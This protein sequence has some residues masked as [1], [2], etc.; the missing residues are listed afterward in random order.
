[1]KIKFTILFSSLFF[2]LNA[3]NI[4]DSKVSFQYIQLPKIKI[5]EAI[6]TYFIS[7]KNSFAS[8]NERQNVLHQLRVD[9]ADKALELQ[10]QNWEIEFNKA[11]KQYL[12][13]LSVWKENENRGVISPKPQEP[14]WPVYPEPYELFPPVLTKPF[15]ELNIQNNFQL[16][17][18]DEGNSGVEISIDNL[19][20]EITSTK[21]SYVQN[22]QTP[23][24]TYKVISKYRMPLHVVVNFNGNK[25]YEKTF[26][27][28]INNFQLF[29]GKTEYDYQLWK[30]KNK[31]DNKDIWEETQS[32][33]WKQALKSIESVLNEE[34]G[35]PVKSEMTE[36][37]VVKKYQDYTYNKLIDA[38]TFAQSAYSSLAMERDKSTAKNNLQ[39]AIILW[40]EELQES[41]I[42]EKKARINKKITGLINANL[43]DAYFWS[44]NF[45]KAN[46]YINQTMTF[47]TL[48]SKSHCKKLKKDIADFQKRHSAYSSN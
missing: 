2:L 30:I 45:E 13:Q 4:I 43:A 23:G 26:N 1:M 36:V 10:I 9:S 6:D 18:F 37:Y 21:G 46:F 22:T 24:K 32:N 40:E 29:T 42:N 39:K 28:K 11:K 31:E 16:S 14:I 19:G 41:D 15:S 3:Q 34:I 8:S 44:E 38:L 25:I 12:T 27:D 33:I 17:G 48:K 35:Y 5:D 20:L 7:Y 47:G